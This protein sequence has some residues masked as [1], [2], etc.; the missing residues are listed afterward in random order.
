MAGPGADPPVTPTQSRTTGQTF[1]TNFETGCE[2]SAVRL[3]PSED[4]DD[5]PVENRG[6]DRGGGDRQQPRGHHVPRDPP[7]D[8]GEALRRAGAH[9]RPGDDVRRRDGVAELRGEVE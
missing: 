8:G 6:D 3:A 7:A 5:G 1:L 9:D 2:A 4:R